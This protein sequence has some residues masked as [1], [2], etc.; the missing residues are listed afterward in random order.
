M[1]Y[2]TGEVMV[3]KKYPTFLKVYVIPVVLFNLAI[4]GWDAIATHI[5]APLLTDLGYA[6]IVT[7]SLYLYLLYLDRY[8]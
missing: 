8:I 7:V 4:G 2:K 5:S 6:V 1:S 3:S